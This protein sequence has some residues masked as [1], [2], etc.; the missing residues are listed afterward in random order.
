MND[1]QLADFSTAFEKAQAA[2]AADVDR[3]AAEAASRVERAALQAADAKARIARLRALAD[4]EFKSTEESWTTLDEHRRETIWPGDLRADV[5]AE[6]LIDVASWRV[7][8]MQDNLARAAVQL[9]ISQ[10]GREKLTLILH[11]G[12]GS[13]KTSTAIAAGRA[14]IAAGYHC[15]LVSQR[16]YTE[17]LMPDGEPRGGLSRAKWETRMKKAP[18]LI[19]DD[20]GA[21]FAAGQRASDFVVKS[22][23]DLIGSRVHSGLTTIVTTN[24]SSDQ[25][26]A[27]FDDPFMSRLGMDAVPVRMV[28]VDLRQPATWGTSNGA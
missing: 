15:R 12:V 27:V 2:H 1:S 6:G 18:V 21:G 9:F 22:L 24:L 28:G 19:L 10:V 3:Y 26:R 14:L 8:N 17:S 13:G 23:M 5:E 16:T 20:L 4:R 25:L 11:G 7:E